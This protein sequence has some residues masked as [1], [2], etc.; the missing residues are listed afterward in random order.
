MGHS[1]P[2]TTANYDRRGEEVR[3]KASRSLHVSYVRR[4]VEVLP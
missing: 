2:T 1:S 4:E 3:R